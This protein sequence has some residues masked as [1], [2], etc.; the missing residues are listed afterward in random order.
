M[1]MT[2]QNVADF[3][4]LAMGNSAKTLAANLCDSY[5]ITGALK[6]RTFFHSIAN[7]NLCIADNWLLIYCLFIAIFRQVLFAIAGDI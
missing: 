6:R 2:R 1:R 4:A 5:W 3:L 7:P